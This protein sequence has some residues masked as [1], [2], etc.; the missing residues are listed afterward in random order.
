[1]TG[2]LES[3]A[4][5]LDRKPADPHDEALAELAAA[6]D[7]RVIVLATRQPPPAE[8]EQP[9]AETFAGLLQPW[10]DDEIEAAR[11][12]WPHVFSRGQTGM[13]PVGEV[14]IVAA[15]GREGKTTVKIGIATALVIGHTLAD[16]WPDQGRSVIVYSAED[17]R[18]QY[19]R[20]IG[21]Q[22]AHLPPS[23]SSW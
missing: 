9:L 22:L 23:S 6:R 4:E 15:Q 7:E 19:A 5:A 14:T 18:Q 17:D 10:T 8:P 11:T 20:K 16:L 13:F 2:D 12:P 3:R 1:M 21:A